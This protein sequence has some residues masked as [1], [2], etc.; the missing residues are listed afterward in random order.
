MYYLHTGNYNIDNTVSCEKGMHC[1]IFKTNYN[2][3][4]VRI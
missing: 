1:H 2:A 3:A 4:E